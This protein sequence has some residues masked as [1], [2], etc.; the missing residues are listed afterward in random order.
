MRRHSRGDWYGALDDIAEC[1]EDAEYWALFGI[2]H[3]GNKH[4][5]GEYPTKAAALLALADAIER[6]DPRR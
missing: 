2:T 1:E 6:L 3:R 4:C 5:V